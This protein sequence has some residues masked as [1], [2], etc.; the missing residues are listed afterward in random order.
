MTTF[1]RTF[2][3]ATNPRNGN[4]AGVCLNWGMDTLNPNF[5]YVAINGMRRWDGS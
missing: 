1:H 3:S 5:N 2:H 4:Q